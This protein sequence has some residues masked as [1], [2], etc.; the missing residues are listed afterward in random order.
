MFLSVTVFNLLIHTFM[1]PYII[2][3][4]PIF[5]TAD[6]ATLQVDNHCPRDGP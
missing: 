5:V 2:I 4:F 6:L 3:D 1:L